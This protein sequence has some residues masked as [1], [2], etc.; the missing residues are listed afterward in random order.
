MQSPPA[1]SGPSGP[2]PRAEGGAVLR[3]LGHRGRL[4]SGCC[5]AQAVGSPKEPPRFREG[6]SSPAPHLSTPWQGCEPGGTFG[7]GGTDRWNKWD[8]TGGTGRWDR[9][10]PLPVPAKVGRSHAPAQPR[11]P[12]AGDAPRVE[13][14]R[15]PR[16]DEL[17]GWLSPRG[18]APPAPSLAWLWCP[19]TCRGFGAALW[20]PDPSVPWDRDAAAVG[21]GWFPGDARGCRSCRAQGGHQH[22]AVWGTLL[23]PFPELGWQE[24]S[25]LGTV[26]KQCSGP[27]PSP[28]L[29]PTHPVTGHLWKPCPV[30]ALM[31]P[32]LCEGPTRLGDPRGTEL[33]LPPLRHTGG[34]GAGA[35]HQRLFVPLVSHPG[36]ALGTRCPLWVGTEVWQREGARGDL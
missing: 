26:L 21:R 2:C 25:R 4:G 5:W 12:G 28:P 9:V 32:R 34:T 18:W 36:A 30:V 24:W 6:L 13:D 14:P 11:P 10:A 20:G 1:A 15:S 3:T 22:G 7:T 8:G 16:R 19:G 23:S 17:L 35:Q 29:L 31:S 27:L 33:V